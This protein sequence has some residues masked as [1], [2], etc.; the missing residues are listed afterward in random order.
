MLGDHHKI[1][2]ITQPSEDLGKH[3]EVFFVES[4]PGLYLLD[5]PAL[6]LI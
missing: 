3:V 4:S 5:E 2:P 1:A 6:R